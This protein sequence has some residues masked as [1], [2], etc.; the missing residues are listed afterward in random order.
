MGAD[1]PA[2]ALR[3]IARV[4]DEPWDVAALARTCRAAAD[5]CGDRLEELRV[6]PARGKT[7]V[8]HTN[9]TCDVTPEDDT[10]PF[11]LSGV[12]SVTETWWG[13]FAALTRSG[14]VVTWGHPECGG[15]SSAV[16]HLLVD[17]ASVTAAECAFAALTRSGTV[18]AWGS[19]EEGSDSSAVQHLLVDVV[20]VTAADRAFA[21][22]TRSGTVV[23]WGDSRFGGDS[24]D[25]QHLL[26]DVVS[27]TAV[28][29]GMFA[30]LTR[31]GTVVTWGGAEYEFGG[32]SSA[33]RDLLGPEYVFRG[34]STAVQHLL[35]DVT[36]VTA[37]GY[38]FAALTRS[39]TVVTWGD[40]ELG[41]DSAAVQH[42]LVDVV[43]VTASECSFAAVTRSG[44][45]VVWGWPYNSDE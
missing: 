7:Y 30:A 43:G 37:T 22:L 20:S 27:V 24:S 10:P 36:S 29:C 35:V 21:A 32:Q 9:G 19:P 13:A 5:A 41:G 45:I 28:S 2:M 11:R 12:T 23:T 3:E 18:V 1:L 16:R 6:E 39:G 38:A 14:T 42:L 33:V 15:D 31:S 44:T 26:V 25:V 17:V 8:L 40:P 4:C 34:D